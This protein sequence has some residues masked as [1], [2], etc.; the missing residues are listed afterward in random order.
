MLESD[1]VWLFFDRRREFDVDLIYVLFIPITCYHLI[2][3][4]L[5]YLAYL[6][7]CRNLLDRKIL[8]FH[9]VEVAN[10]KICQLN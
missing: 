8:I 5:S 6:E 7:T 2:L 3:M 10:F 9:K 4:F 1:I